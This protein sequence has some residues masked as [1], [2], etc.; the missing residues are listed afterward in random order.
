MKVSKQNLPTQ[1]HLSFLYPRLLWIL[2]FIP[3]GLKNP[4]T[5][6]CPFK[7]LASTI[8]CARTFALLNDFLDQ[9]GKELI[10]LLAQQENLLVRDDQTGLFSRLVPELRNFIQ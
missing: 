10:K 4:Y 2:L 7:Q 5:P 3:Q 6:A 1:S 9:W 8:L